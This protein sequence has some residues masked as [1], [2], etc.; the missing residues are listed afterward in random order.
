MNAG[1]IG[2]N[3]AIAVVIGG[4]TLD[5]L[6]VLKGFSPGMII[7]PCSMRTMGD[8]AHGVTSGLVSRAADVCLKER[9]R[10][11]L[12]VRGPR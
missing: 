5:K 12:R 9:R 8:M 3:L 2:M 4:P 6:A 1:A 10:L 7:T 11:V